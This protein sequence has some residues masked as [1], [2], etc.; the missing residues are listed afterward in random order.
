MK[1]SSLGHAVSFRP[2]NRKHL[3]YRRLLLPCIILLRFANKH[4]LVLGRRAFLELYLYYI[5][6]DDRRFCFLRRDGASHL[7]LP[8][9]KTH[10]VISVG[11]KRHRF[12]EI[13]DLRPNGRKRSG[14][15]RIRVWVL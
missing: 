3:A 1:N 10:R 2:V 8:I 13:L 5:R 14:V 4:P 6:P 15:T 9:K 11:R 7:N 12:I